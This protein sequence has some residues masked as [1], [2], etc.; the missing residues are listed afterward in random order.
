MTVPVLFDFSSIIL[1]RDVPNKIVRGEIKA[2]DAISSGEF[3]VEG[4]KDAFIEFLSMFDTF[5]P[6]YNLMTP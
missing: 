6:W 3:K 4:N 5:D 1:G 2:K